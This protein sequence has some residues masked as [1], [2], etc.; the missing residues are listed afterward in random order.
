[1]RRTIIG[2]IF[3]AVGLIILF[4]TLS[5]FSN[6][7][8]APLIFLVLGVF[9]VKKQKR[10]LSR[11]FFLIA[12]VIFFGQLLHID[13][14]S[15]FI[16]L[17]LFYFGWKM[18]KSDKGSTPKKKQKRSKKKEIKSETEGVPAKNEEPVIQSSMEQHTFVRKSFLGEVRYTQSSFD[19]KDMTIWNGMGDVRIDL[20]KAI[21][22]EGET[23]IIVQNVIG[24]IQIYIPEDLGYS[25]QSFVLAGDCSIL[26]S[27]HSGVN[28]TVLMRSPSYEHNVRKVK[29]VLSCA[30]GS[31]KV[32]AI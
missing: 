21:I 11:L 4:N 32:R 26:Q 20:T 15:L 12:I 14:F 22:P 16:A 17:G 7:F 27:K 6:S 8:V 5:F 28:Q 13:F 19:L 23:L 25:I 18:V 3:A 24:D 31:V 29:L 2:S 10:K 30:L 9:F 1:M